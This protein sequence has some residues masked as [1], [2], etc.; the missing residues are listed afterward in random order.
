LEVGR[1]GA[2]YLIIRAKILTVRVG[3][4]GRQRGS[5]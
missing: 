3:F 5:V 2:R 4:D 1:C